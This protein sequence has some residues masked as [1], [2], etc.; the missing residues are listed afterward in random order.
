MS[1]F[2]AF[3]DAK[4]KVDVSLCDGK[5]HGNVYMSTFASHTIVVYPQDLLIEI[6][7]T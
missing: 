2:S 3:A 7:D 1:T 6:G 4:C 5:S